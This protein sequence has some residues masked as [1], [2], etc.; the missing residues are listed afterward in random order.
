MPRQDVDVPALARFAEGRFRPYRPPE[1]DE[2][3]NECLD[4]GGMVGARH[5]MQVAAA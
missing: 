1:A 5:A 3:L 2:M 4:K